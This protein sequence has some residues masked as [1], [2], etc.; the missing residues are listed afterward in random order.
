MRALVPCLVLLVLAAGLGAYIYF[1]ESKRDL[2]DPETRKEKVFTVETGKIEEVELRSPNGDTTLKKN[3][4]TW[5][6]VAPVTVPADEST[7]SSLVS[8]L[9]TLEMQRSLEDNPTSVAQ[10]GLDP[11]RVSV[12]FKVAGDTTQRRLNIG[13]KTPTGS[14]L[15]ARVEGQPKLFLISAHLEDTLNRTTFDLRDKSLLKF[16]RDGVDAIRIAPTG[17]PAVTLARNGA[18]WRLTA[19]VRR[20]PTRAPSTPSSTARRRPRPDEVGRRRR[21]DGAALGAPNL[22]SIRSRQAAA[23][24]RRSAPDRRARSLAIGA[25]KDDATLYAR[26]VSKPARLHGGSE[27]AERPEEDRRRPARQ[28]RVRVQVLHALGS[29]SRAPARPSRSP[30][31]NRTGADATA[32]DDLE[33]NQAGAE[34][35]Q[36][37]GA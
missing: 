37:D 22:K 8:A 3:G 15:Y 11:A 35:R 31:P 7:V 20:V 21:T 33:G 18:D 36:P 5:Q 17:S 23:R 25:K 28:G 9:E 19:P 13:N 4:T 32:A 24:A 12:A 26:D 10:F 34:G 27:P 2:T 6:V 1:V 29:T 30:R 14:D 16:E